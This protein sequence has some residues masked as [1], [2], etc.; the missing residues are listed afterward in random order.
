[1]TSRE[2]PESDLI[3]AELFAECAEHLHTRWHT[4]HPD[5]KR[6]VHSVPQGLELI[7]LQWERDFYRDRLLALLASPEVQDLSYVLS[8]RQRK[9]GKGL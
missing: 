5:S 1:M 8:R 3:D 9:T 2:I 6:M 7:R 4:L